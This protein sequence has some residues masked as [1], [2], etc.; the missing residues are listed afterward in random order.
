M[1]NLT[2]Y[3]LSVY[4]ENKGAYNAHRAFSRLK[5]GSINYRIL[6]LIYDDNT[7]TRKKINMYIGV[8]DGV[9]LNGYRSTTFARMTHD[10]LIKYNPK[11]HGYDITDLGLKF[12]SLAQE[13][14]LF[15]KE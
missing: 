11:N 13:N 8:P 1:K 12:Y 7:L 2:H 10:G 9:N 3:D 5:V 4:N 15:G 6:D 14:F